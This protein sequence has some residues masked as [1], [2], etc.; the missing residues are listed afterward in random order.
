MGNDGNAAKRVDVTRHVRPRAFH[1]ADGGF[2]TVGMVLAMLVTLSLVFSSAQVYR[3]QSAAADVQNVADAAALA[4]ENQV[5]SFY[6]VAQ[7]C[8]AII[9][10]MSLTGIA[11]AGVGVA[12][13]CIPPTAEL[14]VKFIEASQKI[15]RAR[16]KFSENAAKGLDKVQK[17]LP[18]FASAQAFAVAQSNDDVGGSYL[19]CAVLLP[20][21]GDQIVAPQLEGA[22]D[23]MD[24][25]DEE[26]DQ[27]R[28]ASQE[29]EDAAEEANEHKWAA[30]MADCGNDPGYCMYERA[31]SLA[32]LSGSSNP[33]YASVDAWSFSVAIR[34][35]KSYYPRRLAQ[36]TISGATVEEQ[37]D[38]VVRQHFYEYAV[39]EISK[40]YVHENEQAGTFDAYFPLLPKNTAEC[41]RTS[42]W[43]SMPIRK[44]P[45]T[46]SSLRRSSALS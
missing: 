46:N 4:A 34:R 43:R 13:M 5:A 21:Q 6:V 33:Y 24:K 3:I 40:G 22:E 11:V 8:D 27:I 44:F 12:C 20:Y 30:Y 41:I 18:F 42:L 31:G 32:G 36:E 26:D 14:S 16:D 1:E 28:Q 38:S 35:A 9:L 7:T 10:S 45:I 2:S 29:A 15:F 17:L 19:G 37:A 23:A 25:I 39:S